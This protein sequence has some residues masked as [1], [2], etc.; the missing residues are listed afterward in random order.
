MARVIL[1]NEKIIFQIKFLDKNVGYID[2][3]EL[4]IDEQM[5]DFF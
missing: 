5:A 4:E 1:K 2:H 3:D